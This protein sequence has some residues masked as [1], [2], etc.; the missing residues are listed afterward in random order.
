MRMLSGGKATG[1]I[2]FD[3]ES[4]LEMPEPKFNSKYRWKKI[5]M[6]FQGAMNSLDPVFTINEQFLEILK[7]HNF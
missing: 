4:L 2:I 7:Q 6:I 3:D 1:K 5:S